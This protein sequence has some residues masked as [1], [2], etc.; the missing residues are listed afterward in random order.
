MTRSSFNNPR[1]RHWVRRMPSGAGRD[2]QMVAPNR[3]CAMIAVPSKGG[4]RHNV[5]EYT[6]PAEI[7]AGAN[8][9]LQVML[10]AATSQP[11]PA[12]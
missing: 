3:P 2:A 4:I 12:R 7:A 5:R 6:A 1:I 9:L 11:E 10:A 8:L